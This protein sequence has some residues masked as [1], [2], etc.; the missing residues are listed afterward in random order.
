MY[1][2]RH[3]LN[4]LLKFLKKAMGLKQRFV[5]K[6]GT[7]TS[8]ENVPNIKGGEFIVGKFEDTLP[9]FFSESHQ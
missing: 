1:G 8:D 4:I 3:L 6:K 5:E 2:G 7:Y 9:A